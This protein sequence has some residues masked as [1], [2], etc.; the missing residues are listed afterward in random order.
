LKKKYGNII[1]AKTN[2]IMHRIIPS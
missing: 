2:A 1:G